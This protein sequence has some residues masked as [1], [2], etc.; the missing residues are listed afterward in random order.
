[1]GVKCIEKVFIEKKCIEKVFIEKLSIER[2][3]KAKDLAVKELSNKKYI[4]FYKKF[5]VK[6]HKKTNF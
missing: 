5:V 1:M 4:C 6:T 3:F 2:Q